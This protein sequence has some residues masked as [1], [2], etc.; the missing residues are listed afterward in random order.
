MSITETGQIENVLWWM[1][2]YKTNKKLYVLLY[3]G[4]CL[5][6]HLHPQI[7]NRILSLT[8]HKHFS[9]TLRHVR[10]HCRMLSLAFQ[11]CKNVMHKI[12]N[13]NSLLYR[14]LHTWII[15]KLEWVHNNWDINF[16]L[17]VAVFLMLD[18]S[19]AMSH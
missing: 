5:A 4:A 14:L 7:C 15:P 10:T 11:W 13:H 8:I 3:V 2:A 6:T 12:Q 9:E 1:G 16:T 17:V 18:I 19:D